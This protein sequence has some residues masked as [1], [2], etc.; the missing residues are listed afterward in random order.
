MK[1]VSQS[2]ELGTI[3]LA[4]PVIDPETTR[5]VYRNDLSRAKFDTVVTVGPSSDSKRAATVRSLIGMLQFATD[6]ET[7][8]VLTSMIMM[9]MEGEGLKETREFFRKRLVRMGAIEPNEEEM[10]EMQAEL[11]SQKPDANEEL[12]LAEAERS[13]SSALLNQAKVEETAAKT[14][15]TMAEIDNA[16]KSLALSALEKLRVPP[17]R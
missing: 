10:E 11:Q 6:P 1:T 17:T 9:N 7:Q 2:G 5:T 16:D 8:T 14:A 13:R 15:K 12:I 3:E 4:E